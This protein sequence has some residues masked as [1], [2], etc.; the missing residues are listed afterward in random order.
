[1]LN[2]KNIQIEGYGSINTLTYLLDR[3]NVTILSG[4]NGSGKS[5][6][7]NAFFWALYGK[8][9]KPSSSVEMWDHIRPKNY[10]GVKVEIN[11]NKDNTHYRIIRCKNYKE[12]IE[13]KKGANNIFIYKDEVYLD[14]LRDKKDN[15]DYIQDILQYDRDLFLNSV[16]FAQ[17]LD[18]FISES[19]PNKKAILETALELDYISLAM[20]I[21]KSDREEIESELS[22]VSSKEE[23]INNNINGLEEELERANGALKQFESSKQERI[24]EY[25]GDLK[26]DKKSLQ[27]INSQLDK[28][29]E[30]NYD[31][32][33]RKVK[34]KISKLDK[35]VNSEKIRTYKDK[36]NSS[37]QDLRDYRN[38]RSRLDKDID[39][40]NTNLES[41]EKSTC[42]V[43][44]SDL[45]KDKR[46]KLQSETQEKIEDLT[47]EKAELEKQVDLLKAEI[48]NLE[49]ELEKE[50]V[51]NEANKEKIESLNEKLDKLKSKK[52]KKSSLLSDKQSLLKRIK[53]TKERIDKTQEET[54]N[55]DI[56]GIEKKIDLQKTQLKEIK[57]EI[58]RLKERKEDYDWVISNALSNS[59]L[60]TFILNELI[61]TLNNKLS[62]YTF[63]TDMSVRLSINMESKRKDVKVYISRFNKDIPYEDLSG[64]QQQ[65]V[66]ISI[67]FA[68]NETIESNR[69]NY[70]NIS[71]LDEVF[72]SLSQNNVDVV[73]SLIEDMAS[74]EKTFHIVTHQNKLSPQN[75]VRIRAVLD[76]NKHSKYYEI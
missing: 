37:N 24:R 10:Q 45:N 51:K 31:E 6:V 19:G 50:E 63:Y 52:T 18:R 21:A 68:M 47:I 46:L 28:L 59:G 38:K 34:S 57:P 7:F 11:L 43:C 26:E 15:E 36:L 76:E 13:G 69:S 74:P 41:I 58:K 14:Y 20:E 54:F 40:L 27:R 5:M 56:P 12:K 35:L 8:P 73:T 62:K 25:K 64:G 65:L 29:K 30:R 48:G 67:A 16:V 9:L 53:R 72:E 33:I 39:K 42:H 4:E 1:M 60:K 66:D 17:K 22:E 32:I 71:I 2:F 75:S 61:K 44:G 23:L 49:K 3:G 70:C 55:Y